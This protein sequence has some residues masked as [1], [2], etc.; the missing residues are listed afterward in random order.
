VYHVLTV[1]TL[2][3]VADRLPLPSAPTHA[4]ITSSVGGGGDANKYGISQNRIG[5]FVSVDA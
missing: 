2:N 3:E 5:Q 4:G 1:A